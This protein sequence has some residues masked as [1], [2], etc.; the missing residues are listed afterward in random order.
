M[1]N[2]NIKVLIAA[3]MGSSRFPGKTLSQL[4]GSPM[5]ARL[6][7]RIKQSKNYS[8]IVIATTKNPEDD[9]LQAWCE[10]NNIECFRGSSDDVLGRL[11]NAAKYHN[12]NT[13]IE[14]LGDNPLVHS[15]LI[16]SCLDI[17]FNGEYDYVATLTK[18]YPKALKTLKMFPIGVRVQVMKFETL[19]RCEKEATLPKYREHATSYIAE[20]PDKFKTGFLDASG[21][22]QYCSRPELTFAVNLRKNFQLISNIDSYCSKKKENF[23]IEDAINAYDLHPEWWDLMGND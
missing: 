21:K 11:Y 6:I 20:N 23:N 15:S 8:G 17:F 18:E 3:R 5:I 10:E 9:P 19:K 13:I 1:E 16:D 7:D 4:N 2:K 22:Y 12:I 14:I